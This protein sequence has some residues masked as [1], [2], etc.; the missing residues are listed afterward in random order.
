MG[1]EGGKAGLPAGGMVN[2]G[3]A[4][5]AGSMLTGAT[6][7]FEGSKNIASKGMR[8]LKGKLFNF[9]D[10]WLSPVNASIQLALD[11][12]PAD[13]N[14]YERT[15]DA[16]LR[17]FVAHTQLFMYLAV[18]LVFLFVLDILVIVV[19]FW[20]APPREAPLGDGIP[21]PHAAHSRSTLLWVDAFHT[22]GPRW[23]PIEATSA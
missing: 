18:I 17:W 1:P 20:G 16:V 13:A 12:G 19:F 3:G 21:G 6:T 8:P 15:R 2:K 4:A 14:C 5:V 7:L 22:P 10:G 23:R 11:L 9:G